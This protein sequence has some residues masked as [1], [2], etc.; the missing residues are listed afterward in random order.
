MSGSEDTAGG[1]VMK[2]SLL[3]NGKAMNPWLALLALSFGLFMS[4]LDATIV[5]IA[6][7]DIQKNFP[8]SLSLVSWVLNGYNLA[9]VASLVTV[10]HL[11]DLF[12]RKRVFQIGMVVFSLG[13]LFCALSPAIGWLIAARVLQACGAAALNSISL[14]IITAIFPVDKRGA[15]IGIWGALAGLSATIGP[16]LGG[17]L[18]GTWG[19]RS[20]FFLNLPFCLLGLWFVNRWV[21]E[22]R[23]EKATASI[24]VAGIVTLT[25]GTFCLVFAITQAQQ[26]GWTSPRNIIMIA[27]ALFCL[28][29]LYLVERR[30]H[31]PI[32]DL[33]LFEHRSF[34]ATN[35]AMFLY[36]IAVQGAILL[37]VLYFTT[38]RA[39]PPVHAA[40]GVLPISLAA[41]VISGLSGS[42]SQYIKPRVEGIIGMLFLCVGLSL[43]CTLSLNASYLDT[44]WREIIIGIGM[45]LSL[46]AFPK[47]ALEEVPEAKLG[48]GSGVFNT[49]R[50]IGYTLGVAILIS[51]LDVS[52]ST[53]KNVPQ[54]DILQSFKIAWGVA[55][56]VAFLGLVCTF[57][58]NTNY[59]HD[60]SRI[61]GH[62]KRHQR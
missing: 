48:A 24:D 26:W 17:I 28:I 21:P 36:G 45:G 10:G 7:A 57:F 20:I 56:L 31:Q 25:I 9:F 18:V 50:Q 38:A 16:V 49:F 27:I 3:L 61:S 46:I 19:W 22:T 44:A 40:Y 2:R 53:N 39:L 32:I 42:F 12:G 29:F 41:F 60:H 51:I 35:L 62:A 15:A 47:T 30:H 43:L 8:S 5:N 14:A 4:L 59:F 33:S 13:S 55:G 52:L 11:A 6:L 37:M 58:I 54:T 1:K 34:F 23:D